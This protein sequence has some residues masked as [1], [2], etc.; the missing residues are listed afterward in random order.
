MA[1]RKFRT[2][3]AQQRERVRSLMRL[4]S[5]TLVTVVLLSG[6]LYVFHQPF[7]R[8][9]SVSIGDGQLSEELVRASVES[10]L[11]GVAAW[12]LPR[13]SLLAPAVGRIER[14]LSEQFPRIEQVYV[15][16][17][18]PKTL[19]VSYKERVTAALWCGDVIPPPTVLFA[20]T[21]SQTYTG[22]CYLLDE[23]G[24]IF[25]PAIDVSKTLVR[26]YGSLQYPE[27]VGQLLLDEDTFRA[28]QALVTELGK[29]PYRV[30]AIVVLDE[31][32]A[33]LYLLPNTRLIVDHTESFSTLHTR[34]TALL[35]SES[36]DSARDI[37]Y[38][39]MRFGS[40][41]YVKYQEQGTE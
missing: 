32:N 24:Y 3:E 7:M 23:S 14:N 34:L 15:Q 9:E 22:R 10:S 40:K 27:P 17:S 12:G 4:T 29:E 6:L 33:E 19:S 21:T 36:L 18:S 35:D 37:E 28:W 5:L 26:Y 8:I 1:R 20:T 25:S 41:V 13:D 2:K 16:R 11:S 39:D 30:Q 31:R 38:I